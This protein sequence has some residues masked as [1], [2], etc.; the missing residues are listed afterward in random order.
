MSF[1]CMATLCVLLLGVSCDLP[2]AP[3][4]IVLVMC[5]DLGWGDTGFNGNTVIKTPHLDAMAR[6][7]LKLNRFY[8]AAPVCSPT[9]GSVLTGRH[10]YRYGILTANSGHMT[11]QELTLAELLR[12][13]GYTTGHFGKW[14]LGT[15]TKTIRDSNRG[16]PKHVAHFSPPQNNGFDRC[17]STEAKV[18]TFDPMLKP[19]GKPSGNGWN[20]LQDRA[21]AVPYGTRYWDQRGEV[22][23]ENLEGD[24]ARVIMDRAVPFITQAAEQQKPF[25]V[26]VWFHTP[27]LPV[28]AGPDH[29]KLYAEYDDFPRNYYGCITAMDEQV[30]RLRQ[31][32]RDLNVADNTLVTFCS[33]NGPEGQAKTSPGLAGPYRGRKRD[34]YEGG[35]RVPA[36]IEWPAKI[37]AGR[38]SDY[39]AVTSDYLPTILELLGVQI[40][41]DRAIDG[42]SLLPLIETNVTERPSPIGFQHHDALAWTDNRYKLIN[43]TR[44]R[45]RDPNGKP[46]RPPVFEL[47]D[48]LADPQE[49]HD[50]AAEHP[51]VVKRMQTELL[52]WQASCKPVDSRQ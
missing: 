1:R 36:L 41:T 16:G 2:A 32:L 15:M 45:K 8:S 14:H 50:I 10:P 9:R 28:V 22:V 7:G 6:A 48:L 37:A 30:G 12:K 23:T 47:Y 42:A 17:F 25:F 21:A 29:A 19:R 44:K 43:N 20:Y 35:V 51:E 13:Q 27:H 40:P 39:P 31:T 5:D 11:P 33:D 3:P 52:A 18:P 46:L 38:V 49:A 24:D 34:L 4:N 26:V